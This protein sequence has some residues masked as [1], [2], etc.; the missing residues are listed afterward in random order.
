MRSDLRAVSVLTIIA[1]YAF[2]F[3]EWLFFITKPSM[4][5]AMSA[6][7]SFRILLVSPLPLIAGSLFLISIIGLLGKIPW[8]TFSSVYLGSVALLIP[9][10]IMAV[11]AFLLIENFTYTLF[12]FNAGSFDGYA[13]YLYA[14]F[15]L[16]LAGAFFQY[17]KTILLRSFWLDRQ[18][19]IALSASDK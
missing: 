17:L 12:N 2:Y 5:S 1:C 4:F 6:W 7:D 10:F 13:R 15:V 3:F 18:R 19:A 14:L 16:V 11:T 8:K 9:T